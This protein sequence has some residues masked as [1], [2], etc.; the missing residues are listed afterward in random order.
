MVLEVI[1]NNS[2]KKYKITTIQI[3]PSLVIMKGKLPADNTA[4]FKV[5]RDGVLYGDYSDYRYKYNVLTE[6]DDRGYYTDVEGN[7][8]TEENKIKVNVPSKED[9]V[10]DG[11][12]ETEKQVQQN[13]ADIEY[14]A[15]MMEVDLE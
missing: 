9:V 11:L 7:V 13:K 5:Y 1:F 15:M 14:L 4:G 8:E 3:R 10:S 2:K 12:S 6:F